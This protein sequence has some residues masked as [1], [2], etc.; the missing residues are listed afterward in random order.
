MIP[1]QPSRRPLA[2]LAAI[3]A[4]AAVLRLYRIGSDLWL[5]EIATVLDYRDGSWLDVFTVFKSLNNHPLNSLL[6][7]A[8]VGIFGPAEWAVRLP[9]ALFGIATVP[10]VYALGRVA[11]RGRE[12]LLAAFLL[13]V[14]YHHVFFS[15][16]SRGYTG[17]L[18][19]G[20]AGTTFFFRG[21]QRNRPSDWVLYAAVMFLAI[22]SVLQAVFL[23]AGH[24]IAYAGG[25]LFPGDWR[26]PAR[27]AAT[28][29]V[30]AWAAAGLLSIGVYSKLLPKLKAF[31]DATFRSAAGGYSPFSAEF[32]GE[33]A[34]GLAAGIGAKTFL[35]LLPFA[36]AGGA[37]LLLFFRR[38][39]FYTAVL[40]SPLAVTA[41]YLLLQ[42]FHFTPRF[43]LWALPAAWIL[44]AAS[45]GALEATPVGRAAGMARL[46][47]V[48]V[49]AGFAALAAISLPGYYR[50]PKQPNRV[51][52]DWV[53]ARRAAGEP[54]VAAYMA[55]WG[56]RFYGP[57][58]G[59]VPGE[60]FEANDAGELA[61]AE[62][63]SAGKKIWLLTTFSR[64]LRLE[65]PGLDS[66]IREHYR[67]QIRFPATVGD[68]SVTVWTRE[69]GQ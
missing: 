59:L 33:L 63:A 51:S 16:N 55:K 57:P 40:V 11:L 69:P 66:Y 49:A 21:L 20:V 23:V 18:F 12:A 64:G 60:S 34:G 7:K 3:T 32:W 26:R 2:W 44:T 1:E 14:S 27:L 36:A 56:L 39:I 4:L 47:P 9:A 61:A 29:A 30:A 65:R 22:A 17:M 38:N 62:R 68:A 13:A 35:A 28:R 5:D 25:A 43:F 24:A 10:A 67:E 15:Q 42:R 50:T 46:L 37:G 19:F 48:A 52:L 54:V 58:R 8:M 45:V 31:S 41:V 53:L 6:V